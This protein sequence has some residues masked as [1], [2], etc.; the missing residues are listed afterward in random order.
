MA[1]NPKTTV[2]FFIGIL[3]FVIAFCTPLILIWSLN[4]LFSS[5]IDYTWQTWIA[6]AMLIVFFGPRLSSN[7]SS[8]T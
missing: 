1:S 3:V 2:L 5:N 6:A 7:G 8:K 4:T